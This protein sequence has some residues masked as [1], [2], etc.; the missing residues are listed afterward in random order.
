MLPVV[1]HPP[2]AFCVYDC[3]SESVPYA[4]VQT[5]VYVCPPTVG[6]KLS[7]FGPAAVALEPVQSF[8]LLLATQDV[9]AFVVVQLSVVL[10]G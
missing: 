3:V 6:T 8:V 9:G 2:H 1:V 10:A 4:F 5:I 7:V